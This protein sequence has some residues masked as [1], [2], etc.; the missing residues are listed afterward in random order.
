MKKM[1]WIASA[2]LALASCSTVKPVAKEIGLQLYSVR[3]LIGNNKKYD[4]NHTEVFQK[5]ADLGYTEVEVCWYNDGTFFGHP[6]EE[7][8]AVSKLS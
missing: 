5:L 1:L 6:V 7:F 3:D 2:I 4:A 8:K